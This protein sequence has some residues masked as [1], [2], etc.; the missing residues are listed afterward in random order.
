MN[1]DDDSRVSKVEEPLTAAD[2]ALAKKELGRKFEW[3]DWVGEYLEVL[4]PLK[5]GN[6]MLDEPRCWTRICKH[7]QG[8]KYLDESIGEASEVVFCPAFPN[9]IPR[10]IAYGDNPHDTVVKGQVGTIVYERGQRER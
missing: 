5:K 3:N 2:L 10:E 1:G 9:G 4:P 8:V 6:P 7:F